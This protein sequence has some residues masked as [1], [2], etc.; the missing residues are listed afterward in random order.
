MTPEELVLWIAYYS[1]QSDD[2][3]EEMNKQKARRR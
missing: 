1:N 2:Q 3:R